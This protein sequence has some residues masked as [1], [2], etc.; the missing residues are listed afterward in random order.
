LLRHEGQILP[1]FMPELEIQ[2]LDLLFP[3]V[4]WPP[5]TCPESSRCRCGG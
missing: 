2:D 4:S 5:W 1:S 3:A